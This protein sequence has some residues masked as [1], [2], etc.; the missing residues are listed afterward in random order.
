MDVIAFT[1]PVPF[2]EQARTVIERAPADCSILATIVDLAVNGAPFDDARWY[3]IG[4]GTALLGAAIHTP[5]YNLLVTPVSDGPRTAVPDGLRT[6]VMAALAE[7]L[8]AAVRVPS[9]VTGPTAEAHA[10]AEQWQARTGLAPRVTMSERLYEIREPPDHPDVPGGARAADEHDLDLLVRW[11]GE[12]DAEAHVDETVDDAIDRARRRLR[13][14]TLLLWEDGGEPVS[15]AGL[16]PPIAG[17]SRVG[18][19]YTPKEFRRHGYASALTA[20][21]TGLG[22]QQGSGPVVLYTDL[23]NPT[24]N[25]IYQAIGY[26]PVSDA[27]MISFRP[28]V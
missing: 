28:E 1:D 21:A 12:F 17:V 11:F 5:P 24:S 7:H 15:M 20:Q 16:S 2:H 8:Q 18:P 13:R 4:E 6:A 22:L 26:R 23:S 25:R 9:G 14:G 27:M 19:V 3:L 10:F